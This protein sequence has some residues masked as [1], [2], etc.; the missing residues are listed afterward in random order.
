MIQNLSSFIK[1]SVCQCVGGTNIK[2]DINSLKSLPHIVVGSP[3]RVN[4]MISKGFL[5]TDT[6]KILVL[7]EFDEMIY[8]ETI[9]S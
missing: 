4:D 3:G 2:D 8:S 1:I 9:G 5:K 7:D 6:L